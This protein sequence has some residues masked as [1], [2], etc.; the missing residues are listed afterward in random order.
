MTSHI[1]NVWCNANL[2]APVIISSIARWHGQSPDSVAGL[3][4]V[5]FYTIIA[6]ITAGIVQRANGQLSLFHETAA[7]HLGILTFWSAVVGML[8]EPMLD[9]SEPTHLWNGR[10]GGATYMYTSHSKTAQMLMKIG[11]ALLAPVTCIMVLVDHCVASPDN[12]DSDYENITWIFLFAARLHG[13]AG[14]NQ[15]AFSMVNI[16]LP[17]LPMA[18]MALGVLLLVLFNKIMKWIWGWRGVKLL[19][20]GPILGYAIFWVEEIV[21]VEMSLK[22]N[23]GL[24]QGVE[25]AWQFGQVCREVILSFRQCC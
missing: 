10:Y 24:D 21:A 5:Q 1:S 17:F 19:I 8:V 3:W 12:P 18:F 11:Y 6:F 13:A 4:R 22:A 2:R 15:G 7:L 23:P 9:T 25:N 20:C 16:G 14:D